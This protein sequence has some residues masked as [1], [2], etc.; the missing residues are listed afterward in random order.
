MGEKRAE[1]ALRLTGDI[2]LWFE[3]LEDRNR[4]AHT[5][6]ESTAVQVFESAGR[7]PGALRLAI[8]AIRRNYLDP[9]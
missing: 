2:D 7:L 9:A 5:Y 1:V 6:D 4:T 3:M 8:A